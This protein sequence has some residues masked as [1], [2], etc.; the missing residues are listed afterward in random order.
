MNSIDDAY[1]IIRFLRLRPWYDRKYWWDN[2]G[3]LECKYRTLYE[4]LSLGTV[5]NTRWDSTAK[6]AAKKLQAIYRTILYRRK[7]DSKLNG[8][9]LVELPKRDVKIIRLQFT[10]QEHD[11]YKMARLLLS[12]PPRCYCSCSSK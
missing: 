7:K 4:P 9:P 2:L 10:E 3:R 8:K 12:D 1:P 6:E 5:A 11:I